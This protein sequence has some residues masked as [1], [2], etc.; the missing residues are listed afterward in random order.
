MG[1]VPKSKKR[2][3][4]I[5]DKVEL[6]T[7]ANFDSTTLFY[8]LLFCGTD[9][10]LPGARKKE[11][12]GSP[13]HQSERVDQLR[14]QRNA[15]AHA[16]TPSVSQADFQARIQEIEEIY[17]DLQWDETKLKQAAYDQLWPMEYEGLRQKIELE[18]TRI[19]YHEQRLHKL[20]RQTQNLDQQQQDHEQRLQHL[21]QRQQDQETFVKTVEEKVK[22][23]LQT[24]YSDFT[25]PVQHS[26]D[27]DSCR[28]ASLDDMFVELRLQQS[29]YT[30]LPETLDYRDVVEMQKKMQSNKPIQMSQLFDKCVDERAITN[31]KK[32]LILGKAGIGKTTLIKQMAKR[33][34]EKALWKEDV[35]YLFVITLR[36]LRPGEKLTLGDLLLGGLPL[37]EDEK[38]TA[39]LTLRENSQR[40]ILVLE[41]LDEATYFESVTELETRL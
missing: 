22:K 30:N 41:G 27:A 18:K 29:G 17:Q 31:P 26:I 35:D 5:T 13:F 39:L 37:T 33:W 12:R 2:D 1:M 36:Q 8:C 21:E 20:D 4:H 7:T 6:G 10:L 32:I 25:V 19:D 34:A 40:V 11:L 38:T 24:M 15:L 23:A 3:Q 16:T 14:E 28:N 9:L